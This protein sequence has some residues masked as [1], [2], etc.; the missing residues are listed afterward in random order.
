MQI[1]MKKVKKQQQN[2]LIVNYHRTRVAI[3]LASCKYNANGHVML[4]N[5]FTK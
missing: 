2:T 4:R 1:N 5:V 3:T